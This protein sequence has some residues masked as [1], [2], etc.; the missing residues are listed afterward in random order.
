MLYYCLH[1]QW[2]RRVHA[3]GSAKDA[4]EVAARVTAMIEESG[5]KVDYV[6]VSK[7]I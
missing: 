3:D 6:E 1:V 4:A 7:L 2:A 5:G